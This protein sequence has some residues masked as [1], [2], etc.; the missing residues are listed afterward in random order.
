[1]NNE[2]TL[3]PR[4]PIQTFARKFASHL[5]A[6]KILHNYAADFSVVYLGDED[7]ETRRFNALPRAPLR[8]LIPDGVDLIDPETLKKLPIKNKNQIFNETHFIRRFDL[9]RLRKR[10]NLSR[11][12]LSK[13]FN[14]PPKKIA[15][16]L[17]KKKSDTDLIPITCI[18]FGKVSKDLY[19][20]QKITLGQFGIDRPGL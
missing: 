10:C 18:K 17:S 6:G 9:R 4:M 20:Q 14:V 13:L 1:M 19:F 5:D 11:A 2:M 7:E 16:W 15:R 12:D 8:G 3:R